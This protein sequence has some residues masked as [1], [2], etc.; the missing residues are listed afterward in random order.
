M[1]VLNAAAGKSPRSEG[2]PLFANASAIPQDN[3]V[4]SY[5]MPFHFLPSADAKAIFQQHVV[6][7]PYGSLTEVPNAQ[8]L[9]I[10][11]NATLIRQLI[12]LQELIDVPPARVISEFV[13]LQR[14]DAE[15]VA[16]VI[17]K[18]IESQRSEK[19]KHAGGQNVPPAP[20]GQPVSPGAPAGAND[21]LFENELVSGSVQLVPDTR[22][23]RILVI[24]RPTNFPYI[25][26]LIGE[27]DKVVGLS[28]PLE[29]PLK[30]ISAAE[31]LPVLADLLAENQKDSQNSAAAGSQ[32][33]AQQSRPAQNPPPQNNAGSSGGLNGQTSGN[34][35][36]DVLS[37]PDG[38]TG[39]T[40]LIV[41]K[42]RLIAD[43]KANSILVIGPPESQEK[44]R[45]LLD[46]LDK[47]PPQVYLST[48]I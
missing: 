35:H 41:G 31:V 6:L 37:E 45:T 7:H 2:V 34:S 17:T 39:P 15:R 12:N 22:T 25:K 21:E 20:N 28:A 48:V 27:F 26:N 32:T 3:Q 8:A 33:S 46:K 16:D 30:Y 10:T 11:E 40:S 38:D 44:V 29:R 4:V 9:V 18:L 5:F 1:K 24:T 36:P 42:T 23:N 14:A 19:Q 13:T 43:N 47:Q